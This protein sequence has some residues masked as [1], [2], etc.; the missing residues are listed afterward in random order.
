MAS[1]KTSKFVQAA[2]VLEENFLE[3]ERLAHKIQT[4]SIASD[5]G[6]E[7]AR[8]LLSKLDE[9][10]QRIA[11]SMLALTSC[12]EDIRRRTEEA[13]RLVSVQS[14]AVEHRKLEMEKITEKLR[15]LGDMA[16]QISEA[17]DKLQQQ[18]AQV[19]GDPQNQMLA[20][21]LPEFAGQFETLIA[22]V[23]KIKVE[24]Q[25]ANLK[26]FERNADSLRQSLQSA[27]HRLGLLINPTLYN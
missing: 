23:Q 3:F 19:E 17:I 9:C 18:T 4:L 1:D 16:K 22:E 26:L 12:L 6:F 15:A 5:S 21:H 24:A 27:K 10:G 25:E 11:P 8:K 7:H 14:E 20:Q 13:A 2:L